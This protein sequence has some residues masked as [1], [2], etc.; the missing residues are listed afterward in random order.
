MFVYL[1]IYHAFH[2]NVLKLCKLGLYIHITKL[3][4]NSM[5]AVKCVS[6]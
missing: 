6:F 3:H 1:W 4:K 5:T 2:A